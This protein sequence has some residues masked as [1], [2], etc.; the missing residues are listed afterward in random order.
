MIMHIASI[1]YCFHLYLFSSI[2]LYL[3]FSCPSGLCFDSYFLMFRW[4]HLPE[5]PSATISK[6]PQ[7]WV[8][9]KCTVLGQFRSRISTRIFW[10][11][12][13]NL[14]HFC[15]HFCSKRC[16]AFL[17]VRIAKCQ[18]RLATGPKV[19]WNNRQLLLSRCLCVFINRIVFIS[20]RLHI[21]FSA[22]LISLTCK[23]AWN[24]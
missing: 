2:R 23:L 5:K 8:T 19:A 1:Y 20:C 9:G 22:Y 3:I 12:T 15:G 10:H 13:E 7:I 6:V 16:N 17:G 21:L 11:F 4:L 18:K 14:R 24:G